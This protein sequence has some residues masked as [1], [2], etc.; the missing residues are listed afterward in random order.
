M[1][2]PLVEAIVIGD[3]TQSLDLARNLCDTGISAKEIVVNGIEV[4]MAQLDEKCTMEQFNLLEIMLT[5]RAAMEVMKYLFPSG[6]MV[7]ARKGTI[8]LAVLEGDV[9]D[10]GKNI[11]KMILIANGYQVVDCGKN[12]PIERLLDVIEKEK[13]L[14]I[15]LSGLIFP[16]IP[17]VKQVKEQM[18]ARGIYVPKIM[19][20][21]AALKQSSME[22]LNVDFLAE[23]AF[24][25]VNYLEQLSGGESNE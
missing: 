11:L 2:E 19:V 10:I 4:A 20:G 25:S 13:P 21:G 17:M 23:T 5:G 15:G 9:H 1:M 22:N 8:V 12:C 7:T 16:V 14:A 3:C 18:Q 24:D 6:E